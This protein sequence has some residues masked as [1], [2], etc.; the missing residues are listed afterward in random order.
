[1]D[2]CR[3]V[4]ASAENP[5][6]TSALMS[7]GA[8]PTFLSVLPTKLF[9]QVTSLVDLFVVSANRETRARS[10]SARADNQTW[11]SLRLRC[12]HRLFILVL[13]IYVFFGGRF[14]LLFQY[15]FFSVFCF[16]IHYRSSEYH[17]YLPWWF[18]FYKKELDMIDVVEKKTSTICCRVNNFF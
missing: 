18:V 8:V 17:C 3:R 6:Q 14:C 9:F 10:L 7:F 16:H 11:R 2:G 13:P 1:M 5:V 15:I 4:W 12:A